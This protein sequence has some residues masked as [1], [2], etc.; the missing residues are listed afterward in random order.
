MSV[1]A[2]VLASWFGFQTIFNAWLIALMDARKDWMNVL[3]KT[4]LCFFMMFAFFMALATVGIL[5]PISI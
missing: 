1:T 3:V 4:V 5:Q 2:I